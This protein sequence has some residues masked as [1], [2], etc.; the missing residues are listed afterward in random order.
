[1]SVL[2]YHYGGMVTK[3]EEAGTWDITNEGRLEVLTKDEE[4]VMS[5][6]NQWDAVMFYDPDL[7]EE[8]E[9]ESE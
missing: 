4:G 5:V 3:F 9:E 6:F 1:M 7:E 2:V 8:E